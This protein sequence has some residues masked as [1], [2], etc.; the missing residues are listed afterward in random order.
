MN[1]PWDLGLGS[2]GISHFPVLHRQF[3]SPTSTI[4]LESSPSQ[5]DLTQ[6][7]DNKDVLIERLNDLV[8]RLSKDSSFDDGIVS[9]IHAGVDKIELLMRSKEKENQKRSPQ[10][11][12]ESRHSRG[13]SEDIIW[14]SPLTPSRN[15]RMRFPDSPAS[16]R[17]SLHRQPQMTADRAIE[18]AKSAEDL[19]NNLLATVTELQ[20]RKEESDVS[21]LMISTNRVLQ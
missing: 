18:I 12:S 21:T 16:P 2:P 13:N 5:E 19:S 20:T 17:P 1:R 3:S 4:V 11:G 10:A 6:A 9:A 14:G 8:L 7:Q 15:I